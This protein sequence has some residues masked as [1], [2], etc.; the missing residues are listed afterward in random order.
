MNPE[1]IKHRI[2]IQLFEKLREINE[3]ISVTLVG[4]FINQKDLVGISDIDTIV[5]CNSLNKKLFS[6]CIDKIK[7]IDLK[8][9]GLDDYALK[10]NSTFGPLK[11]DKPKLA[12]IHL[13]IYDI[14]LHRQHVIASP[15]TCFDWERSNIVNGLSLKKIFPTGTLQLRDFLE[16]RRSIENYIDDLKNN[17]ISYREYN[18]DHNNVIQIK[19]NKSLDQRHRGEYV[20]HIIRNLVT[21]YLK[22]CNRTNESYT[23]NKIKDTVIK[24]LPENSEK[25]KR[26][27]D[28]ISKI[29]HERKQNFPEGTVKWAKLFIQK[30]QQSIISE[31]SEAVPIYFI[32]H[33]KTKL[34]DGTF[35]GQGRDPGINISDIIKINKMSATKVY[36]SPL[37][38]C[39]ETSKIFCKDIDTTIDERLKEFDYGRAEGLSFEE[40]IEKYPEIHKSWLNNQDPKFPSGEN[41]SDVYNRLNSFLIDLKEKIN[42]KTDAICVI[43]HNG[44]LRC[45][46]GS[47]FGLDMNEWHKLIIPHGIPL[48]FL[49][50]RDNYYPNIPRN[51]WSKILQNIGYGIS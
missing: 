6:D 39:L 47:A 50:W 24:L 10:I 43:T 46:L 15:F 45:L 25:H 40:F 13:M 17:V 31:W 20:Y 21:N 42:K 14:D 44:I 4:S 30:F 19:K 5:I 26:F 2:K 29:K 38:R 33:Y 9:C 37:L 16:V 51:S 12:V 49:Y 8:E 34:N 36:T 3:I 27:F 35:L 41:T 23:N 32:R 22:L 18:F 1:K 11:F 28:I 7:S 48:E